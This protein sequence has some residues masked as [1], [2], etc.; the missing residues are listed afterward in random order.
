MARQAIRAFTVLSAYHLVKAAESLV[1]FHP[2]A[3]IKP[4]GNVRLPT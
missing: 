4:T 2:R 3:Q 1:D